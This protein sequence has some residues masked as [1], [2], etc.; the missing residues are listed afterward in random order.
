MKSTPRRRGISLFILVAALEMACGPSAMAPAA[1]PTSP[2]GGT[3][4]KW[5]GTLK[6]S[7]FETRSI[8]MDILDVD[9]CVDGAWQTAPPEWSGTISGLA[10]ATTISLQVLFDDPGRAPGGCT[11]VGTANGDVGQP[12]MR[13]T[14][15][16]LAPLSCAG[17]LP[18]DL[19][20]DLRRP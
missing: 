5:I 14:I 16:T 17:I 7:N 1:T 2:T 4:G 10:A 8:T 15:D 6:S 12:T 18:R 3:S 11:A 9:G 13:W 20:F 19:V